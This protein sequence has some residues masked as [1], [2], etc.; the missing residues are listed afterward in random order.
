[1]RKRLQWY[2]W[3]VLLIVVQ[4]C[5]KDERKLN[6]FA[7]GWTIEE[8]QV[9]EYRDGQLLV[10][11]K[12][13]D[14]GYLTLY[15]NTLDNDLLNYTELYLDSSFHGF[16]ANAMELPT[17]QL[18]RN[19]GRWTADSPDNDRIAFHFWVYTNEVNLR[20]TVNSLKSKSMEFT[21]SARRFYGNTY[22]LREETY[23]LKR[24]KF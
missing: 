9:K 20:A 19:T 10:D 15:D 8:C 17:K 16:M 7:G 18:N 22:N 1:M 23:I 14:I 11:E 13:K 5:D 2:A 4:A 3:I 24:S 12:Y 21:I 6:K